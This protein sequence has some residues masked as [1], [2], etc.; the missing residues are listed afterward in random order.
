MF[1]NS[2]EGGVQKPHETGKKKGAENKMRR[3]AKVQLWNSPQKHSDSEQQMTKDLFAK[4]LF[5]YDV[6]YYVKTKTNNFGQDL[7]VTEGREGSQI[8]SLLCSFQISPT[9]LS[10]RQSSV[11]RKSGQN[12]VVLRWNEKKIRQQNTFQK[13]PIHCFLVLHTS[14]ATNFPSANASG[15]TWN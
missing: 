5:Q 15:L 1:W 8:W 4:N 9:K 2:Y 3:T 11:L 12:A 14:W 7:N 6:K 13:K 10:G